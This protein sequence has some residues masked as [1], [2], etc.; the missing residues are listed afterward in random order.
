MRQ[1]EEN[2]K[3][4]SR[5][6][7]SHFSA[8][9]RFAF[10]LCKNRF[11]TDDL[12]SET[13]LKAFENFDRVRD[14]SKIKQW[15]FR[16]LNNQFISNYRSRKMVV[17]IEGSQKGAMHDDMEDFSLFEAI[18][19]SDFVEVGN[20]EKLFISNLTQNQIAQAISELPGEFRETLM[21]CDIEEFAYAEIS[22]ILKIPI[23][24][25]RSRISRARNM[26]QKKL[27][28]QAQE[29]GIKPS[30]LPKEKAGYTCTCGKDEESHHPIQ[31]TIF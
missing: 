9:Q 5:I 13:F 17:E 7:L 8:V 30:K 22:V 29:L 2:K 31:E 14:E 10:S 6:V 23:G 11:D 16:I 1:V 28:L 26:L 21:L 20:P 3:R 15:L 24:T 18:A 4:F 19:K 27:W 12:V 25:V